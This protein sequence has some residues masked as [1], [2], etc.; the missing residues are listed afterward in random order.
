MG[1]TI[2]LRPPKID[3]TADKGGFLL[4]SD[5]F[6]EFESLGLENVKKL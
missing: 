5:T 6:I 4:F 3:K 1:I 2:Q